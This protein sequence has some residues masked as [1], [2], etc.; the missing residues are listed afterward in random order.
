MKSISFFKCIII[1]MLSVIIISCNQVA[2]EGTLAFAKADTETT[3][4]TPQPPVKERSISQEFKDYWYQGKA[5]ITSYKLDQGRYG[6]VRPG[7]AVMIYVTEDFLPKAQVKADRQNPDNIPV[8]KLNATKKFNTGIY[9]YSIMSSTFYP[10]YQETH[11]LKVSQSMQEWCGQ[12]YAQLNNREQF[13]IK[14]HSYFEGE[15]D[16][17]YKV[18]KTHLE[19]EIWTQ[20]RINPE[21]LPTGS[22]EIIPDFSYSRLK[23][24]PLKAYTARASHEEGSYRLEYPELK[25]TLVINYSP[26]FPYIINSWEETFKSGWGPKA[27]EITT[28]ATKI[29][30]IKSAYWGKNDNKDE[31][32][33][34]DLGLN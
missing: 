14:S 27:K 25:R 30:T 12:Q 31:S 5:E 7:T 32:L 29:N 9:P 22:I 4:A 26:E 3:I 17:E 19:N 11:A 16:K 21:D 2:N 23:H 24:I 13:E 28:T 1:A 8:M 33:R 6:E 10:V 20:L 34:A 15:E 18:A